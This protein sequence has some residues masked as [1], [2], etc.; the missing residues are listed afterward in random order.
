[1]KLKNTKLSSPILKKLELDLIK[2]K[3]AKEYLTK[4]KIRLVKEKEVIREKIKKEKEVIKL[5]NKINKIKN[6]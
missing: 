2:N 6:N 4:E 1:M 3:K 5:R